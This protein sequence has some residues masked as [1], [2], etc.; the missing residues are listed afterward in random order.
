MAEGL[1][2]GGYVVA[3]ARVTL[4]EGVRTRLPG[5]MV[6]V[7]VVALSLAFFAGALA[8][9][10]VRE[11]QAAVLGSFLRLSAVLVMTLFVLT[12]QIREFNDKGVDLVLSLPIPRAGYFLGRLLGFLFISLAVALLCAMANMVFAPLAQAALW[13]WSLFF[14]LLIVT[15]LALLSLFTFNQVPAAFSMV[16]A[17][18]FLARSVIVLQWVGQG[19]IMPQNVLYV[20]LMNRFID[21][22]AYLLPALDRFTQSD[23]LVYGSGT[24]QDAAFV[25]G[26]GCV[27]LA[28]LSLAALVDLYRKNF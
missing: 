17:V 7:L 26:Q 2:M 4:L 27:Y 25:G 8:V 9:T 5:L 21:A 11:I 13:G 28:L 23:W 18:Y 15:A 22:L 24:W 1:K 16:M 14:E 12:A 20:W 19:P 10:E 3:I 6:A